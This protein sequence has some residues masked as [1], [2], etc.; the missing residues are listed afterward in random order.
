MGRNGECRGAPQFVSKRVEVSGRSQIT[1]QIAD[2]SWVHHDERSTICKE[3][4]CDG[5]D[6]GGWCTSPTGG[7]EEVGARKACRRSVEGHGISVLGD[8]NRFRP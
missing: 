2:R 4:S 6:R 8:V 5:D 7:D 1:E 3:C